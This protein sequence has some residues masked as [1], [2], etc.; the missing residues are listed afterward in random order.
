M[1]NV[2]EGSDISFLLDPPLSN[3]EYW[4]DIDKSLDLNDLTTAMPSVS[5]SQKQREQ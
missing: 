4:V 3:D 2:S 1:G 5:S